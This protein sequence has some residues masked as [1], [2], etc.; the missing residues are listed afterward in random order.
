MNITY[1]VWALLTR[2]L[3][4]K[5]VTWCNQNACL[6]YTHPMI[7][8]LLR[9]TYISPRLIYLRR[10]PS[11]R[12]SLKRRRCVVFDVLNVLQRATPWKKKKS[13]IEYLLKSIK[14][15]PYPWRWYGGKVRI[16]ETLKLRNEFFSCNNTILSL[17]IGIIN[18]ERFRATLSR[19]FGCPRRWTRYVFALKK[20]SVFH[21]RVNYRLEFVNIHPFP[22]AGRS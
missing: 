8:D 21:R 12:C 19:C 13:E 17:Q 22:L 4:I 11:F 2:P 9:Y 20:I 18:Y 3:L 10:N 14:S 16:H 6:Y 7:T 5:L 15:L 1:D